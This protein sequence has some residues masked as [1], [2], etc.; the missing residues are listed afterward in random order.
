MCPRPPTSHKCHTLAQLNLPPIGE[1]MHLLS[2]NLLMTPSASSFPLVNNSMFINLIVNNPGVI[3]L[4][5]NNQVINSQICNANLVFPLMLPMRMWQEFL[6]TL[7]QTSPVC[8]TTRYFI[9]HLPLPVHMGRANLRTQADSIRSFP[10][11]EHSL[12]G[13]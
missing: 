4:T 6:L 2:L 8:K 10:N 3:T 12:P 7:A 5:A 11:L 9:P 1:F 13:L